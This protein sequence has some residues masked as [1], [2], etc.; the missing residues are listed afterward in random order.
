MRGQYHVH[1]RGT[2]RRTDRQT[3]RQTDRVNPIY[4]FLCGGYKYCFDSKVS[5]K[6]LICKL[7]TRPYKNQTEGDTSRFSD[8]DD[9]THISSSC[10]KY[11]VCKI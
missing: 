1:R 6:L 4:P 11:D 5:K 7:S 8:I 9:I 2:D 10:P 3:R